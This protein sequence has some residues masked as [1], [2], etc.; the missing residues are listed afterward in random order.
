[1][2]SSG[3]LTTSASVEHDAE[4]VARLRLDDG[5]GGHAAD[6]DVVA[7]AEL[8]V[9]AQVPVGDQL[10]GRDRFAVGVELIRAQEHLVR[11]VRG[12]G[13]VLVDE[14]RGGVLVLVDVVGVAENAVGTRA[15]WWPASAP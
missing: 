7:V 14:R 10:A 9:G 12:I 6:L 3:T 5:P 8:A 2:A 4:H 1:M 13:L 11:G 15:G